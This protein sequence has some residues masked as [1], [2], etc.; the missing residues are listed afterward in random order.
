ML[1][2]ITNLL[3]YMFRER[4]QTIPPGKGKQTQRSGSRKEKGYFSKAFKNYILLKNK[5]KKMALDKLTT[6]KINLLLII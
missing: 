4:I 2:F 3:P 1:I 5:S 6:T